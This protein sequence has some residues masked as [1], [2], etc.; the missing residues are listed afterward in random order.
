[1]PW[2]ELQLH[3]PLPAAGGGFGTGTRIILPSA[4]LHRE[5]NGGGATTEGHAQLATF[6]ARLAG[7]G[8]LR[9]TPPPTRGRKNR[10]KHWVNACERPYI[11]LYPS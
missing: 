2:H 5:H 9:W 6:R 7:F 3:H 8:E 10:H 1:M 4:P 11:L